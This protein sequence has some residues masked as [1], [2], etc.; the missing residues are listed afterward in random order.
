MGAWKFAE[1]HFLSG[2]E[3]QP[4]HLSFAALQEDLTET[5]IDWCEQSQDW[6]GLAQITVGSL[7]RLTI[8]GITSFAC[9]G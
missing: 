8:D 5:A 4:S 7:N 9:S 2:F 3:T 1:R 6:S